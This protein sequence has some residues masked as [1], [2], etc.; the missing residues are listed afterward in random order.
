MRINRTFK[1]RRPVPGAIVLALLVGTGGPIQAAATEAAPNENEPRSLDVQGHRGCRGLLPENSMP[2]FRKALDLR[3]TTLE[4]DIQTTRDRILIVYHD[5]QLDPKRCI[6]DDGRKVRKLAFKDLEYAALD[7]VDCGSLPNPRFPEQR[8]V[9]GTRIPRLDEVLAL[10]EGADYAVGFNIE[11]KMQK[12]S[13]GVPVG[14]VAKLLVDLVREHG[15][16]ERTIVQSFDPEALRE[17]ATLAPSMR[18][19]LLT[20]ASGEKFERLLADS[21]GSRILSPRFDRLREDDVRRMHDAGVEVIPWTV[22]EQADI[23]RLIAWGVDGIISD[24]PERVL[25]ITGE[26]TTPKDP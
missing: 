12:R 1:I 14:E 16:E 7:D 25:E 17:V 9:P 11:I 20:R 5:Q 18:R 8:R 24:Y 22:N 3:V 13:H 23:R 4:L 2:A 15:L 26:T 6:H 19:A 21:G 10:A